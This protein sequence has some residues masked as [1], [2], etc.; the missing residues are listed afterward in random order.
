MK[1]GNKIS[2]Y[3]MKM[4]GILSTIVARFWTNTIVER[5][6]IKFILFPKLLAFTNF[7]P[8]SLPL[9][10]CFSFYSNRHMIFCFFNAQVKVNYV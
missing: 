4:Y 10:L 2:H 5:Q 1:I 7:K 3:L 9:S 8:G 6:S